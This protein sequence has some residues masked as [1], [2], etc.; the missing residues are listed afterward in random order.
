MKRGHVVVKVEFAN[1]KVAKIKVRRG[2]NAEKLARKFVDDHSLN[3]EYVDLLTKE[4][5][6]AMVPVYDKLYLESAAMEERRKARQK[7]AEEEIRK[8][9]NEE[10]Q[11]MKSFRMS[12][13]S[14]K[15]LEKK[16][17][18]TIKTK[19]LRTKNEE[20]WT[21]PRCGG[22]NNAVA[23]RCTR[24][25]KFRGALAESAP[26][27]WAISDPNRSFSTTW[28]DAVLCN[29]TRPL[30]GEPT[31]CSSV[32]RRL[33]DRWKEAENNGRPQPCTKTRTT[34]CIKS[35]FQPE[36]NEHSRRLVE[37]N[38][39]VD[40]LVN[41]LE[42]LDQGSTTSE[43]DK[44]YDV[45]EATM[46]ETSNQ[47]KVKEQREADRRR[48]YEYKKKEPTLN[49]SP[50][51]KVKNTSVHISLHEEAK[52]R[53]KN[54]EIQASEADR[55]ARL[56]SQPTLCPGS[57][58]AW[59]NRQIVL[60]R[61]VYDKALEASYSLTP[62][63]FAHTCS[64][65]LASIVCALFSVPLPSFENF[66][67][68]I[69]EATKKLSQPTAQKIYNAG[70]ATIAS[71][72]IRNH[73]CHLQKQR[74]EDD[75]QLTFKPN[76]ISSSSKQNQSHQKV[77]DR[78]YA[79]AKT[80]EKK[81]RAAKENLLQN[82]LTFQPIIT[83]KASSRSSSSSYPLSRKFFSSHLSTSTDYNDHKKH[84]EQMDN[85]GRETNN[86]QH[87]LQLQTPPPPHYNDAFLH[88]TSD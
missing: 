49:T 17:T 40:A 57:K 2:D 37:H 86:L 4:I 51:I 77:S 61:N 46:L 28:Q 79:Y 85:R 47:E 80:Y 71:Q 32:S 7:N 13:A 14:A 45:Y 81:R 69:L 6:K 15:I 60:L 29:A 59:Q 36:I 21:C 12:A 27:C 5:K 23:D 22:R 33:I 62:D 25:L 18:P 53:A 74:E 10:L 8:K 52:T 72:Q 20:D 19:K 67:K 83:P 41:A 76:L 66:K 73:Q 26:S 24:F 16:K 42:V 84:D 35:N 1:D 3:N 39:I 34:E 9:E 56:K 64:S 82:D 48:C 30:P 54:K 38:R 44:A 88:H 68:L 55:K 87:H 11:K 43:T 50:C 75:A 65:E 31:I 58:R 70:Q 78:L 63:L